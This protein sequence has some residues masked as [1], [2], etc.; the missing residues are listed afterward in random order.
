MK[1][2]DAIRIIEINEPLVF[3]V[4]STKI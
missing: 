3:L 2:E 4:S 1:T